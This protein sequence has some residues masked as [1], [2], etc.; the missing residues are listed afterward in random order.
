MQDDKNPTISKNSP[1]IS[2]I[3]VE[4]LF[5]IYSYVLDVTSLSDGGPHHGKL[6]LLYGNNGSGK[7][8]IL[9]LVYHLLHPE[10]YGGHRSFVGDIPFKKFCVHLFNGLVVTAS[11]TRGAD[12]GPYQLE[13]RHPRKRISL[14]YN[15]HP[16]RARREREEEEEQ[17]YVELCT[18]LKRLGLSFH[19]LR[20]SRRVEGRSVSAHSERAR[21]KEFGQLIVSDYW[22]DHE[23]VLQPESELRASVDAAVQWFRERALSATNVGYTSVNVIYRDII[24]RI[25]VAGP[26][27]EKSSESEELV[28]ALLELKD[29]NSTYARLGITP[30]LDVDEIV[31]SLRSAQ[32]ENLQM[33]NTVLGPYLDGHTARLDALAEVQQVMS[34]FVT[35]LREFYSHKQVGVHLQDG[36]KILSEF[37]RDRELEPTDLSSGERQLL[38]L[39]CNAISS[40]R[41]RAIL[42]IDEPE[43]SLNVK[44]QR[45]LIPALLTCLSGT[46]FQ[47]ILAT[48]SVELISQYQDS[49]ASLDNIPE[50]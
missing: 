28:R 2:R 17:E 31:S 14:T 42:M 40:R 43:I 25:V 13:L 12:T 50:A 3:E 27:R 18:A 6:L 32:A 9:N 33:L 1:L 15:W 21:R 47:L 23:G 26:S 7:T 37:G 30:E 39:F 20:D 34:S 19:Y 8:T 16:E 36:I 46:A 35:L 24:K 5:H 41:D 22:E 44:W 29:R 4:K 49:V 45:K 38:L 48:H 11:R 10:P